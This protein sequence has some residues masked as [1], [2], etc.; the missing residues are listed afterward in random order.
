MIIKFD[1]VIENQ[2]HYQPTVKL[3]FNQVQF[4]K[5]ITNQ[6]EIQNLG[7]EV[8]IGLGIALVIGVSSLIVSIALKIKGYQ[9][10]KAT[11]Q[12]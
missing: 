5:P 12:D 2:Y 11:K 6:P 8:A 4:L 7:I 1:Y 3:D 9:K 10:A